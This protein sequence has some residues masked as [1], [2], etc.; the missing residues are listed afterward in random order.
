MSYKYQF[1]KNRCW[2][3]DY[4][5]YANT[6]Q[7]R[8]NCIRFM[9]MDYLMW[10]SNIP[11]KRQYPTPLLASNVDVGAFTQLKEIGD[12]IVDF[13]D[14]GSNLYIYSEGFGNGKTSWSLKLMLKYFDK[15]WVGNGFKRRGIFIHVPTFIS[16]IKDSFN[17]ANPYFERLKRDL[18]NVDIVV[19]DDIASTKLSD[20]DHGILLTYINQRVFNFKTNIYTGNLDKTAIELAL[21]K[22]LASRVWNESRQ[23]EFKGFDRRCSN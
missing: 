12:N 8:H 20:F 5:E 23:I 22:R 14:N 1:D 2:Y 18:P 15:I 3:L 10:S 7:C 11:T 16:S 17:T 9:E 21:G 13:V 6:E 4:C 19:W